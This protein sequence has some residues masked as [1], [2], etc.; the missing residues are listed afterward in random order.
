MAV[1]DKVKAFAITK[2]VEKLKLENKLRSPIKIDDVIAYF[3]TFLFTAH[4][5]L[6]KSKENHV[7]HH[8]WCEF[9]RRI[10]VL[11]SLVILIHVDENIAEGLVNV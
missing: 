9:N 7:L 5:F 11:A 2:L 6:E 4:L 1:E 3:K 10:D 8:I